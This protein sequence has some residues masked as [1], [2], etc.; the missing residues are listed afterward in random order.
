MAKFGI[1]LGSGPRGQEFE[2]PH[3]DHKMLGKKMSCGENRMTSPF[4]EVFFSKKPVNL[5]IIFRDVLSLFLT[6]LGI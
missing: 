2:S 1:A 5:I 6:T 4:L 3:S